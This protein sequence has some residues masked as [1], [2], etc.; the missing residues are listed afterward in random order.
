MTIAEK[1]KIIEWMFVYQSQQQ[2]KHLANRFFIVCD[3]KNKYHSLCLKND[4]EQLNKK[5][6]N[7]LKK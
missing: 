7:I 1:N 5:L 2:R 6:K 4:A 3:G